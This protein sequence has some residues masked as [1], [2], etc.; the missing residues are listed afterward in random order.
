[1]VLIFLILFFVY[2]ESYDSTVSVLPPE[3]ESQMGGLSGLLGGGADISNLL[4]AGATNPNSQLNIEVL[5]SR[6]AAEYVIRKYNLLKYYNADNMQEAVVKLQKNLNVELT[7]EGIVKLNVT[8][9]TSLFPFFTNEKKAIRKLSADLSNSYIS[10]LDSINR[11]KLTSKAKKAREYIEEQIITTKNTLDS[12]EQKLM[13][14]QKSNKTISLPE[15][16]K[17]AI[18][19]AAKLKAE[20]TTTEVE[21]GMVRTNLQ[22]N[23]R[24]LI[25]LKNKLD[26][27]KEQ[28]NKMEMGSEDYLVSFGDVPQ[29][30]KEL[31]S[32]L[33]EVKIQNEVYL[34][35]QQQYYREKIQENKDMPTVEVLDEAIR[36]LKPSE[37]RTIYSSALGGISVFLLVSLMLVYSEQ[38]KLKGTGKNV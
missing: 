13:Y 27:L 22:E 4:S 35:L 32:L 9:S 24:T 1:M 21:L 28:Y 34:M 11:F 20:I 31:A 17:A 6:S 33:R 37:P 18:E 8:V 38:K 3:K 16:V 15:Q 29:L 10:A 5:K 14:F 2:P 19:A 12:M 30:G 36:P 25:G 23:N 7:K 26:Q